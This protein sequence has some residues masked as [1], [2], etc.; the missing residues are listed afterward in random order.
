MIDDDIE[1]LEILKGA[2]AT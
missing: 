1:R 2:S